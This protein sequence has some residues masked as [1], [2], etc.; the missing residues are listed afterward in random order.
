MKTA[1][2]ILVAVLAFAVIG[3]GPS[4]EQKKMLSDLTSEVTT[5]INDTKSS[6]GE[7]D[8]LGSQLTSALSSGDSLKQKFPKD[9]TAINAALTQLTTAKNRVMTVKDNVK[10]WIDSYKAPD[11][12]NLKFD[13]V[14]ADLK[15][16]K[17]DLSEAKTEVQG[18]MSAASTALDNYNNVFSNMMSKVVAKKK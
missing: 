4:A 11:L 12:A 13:N 5:M 10:A 7:L 3:C 1:L 9:S 2:S 14:I 17:D 15:K 8:G 18:A 6:L 16:S